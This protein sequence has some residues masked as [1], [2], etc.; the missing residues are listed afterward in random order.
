MARHV[1]ATVLDPP[2]IVAAKPRR[3]R[4]PRL[5]VWVWLIPLVMTMG[6]LALVVYA[7]ALHSWSVF[8]YGTAVA[9]AGIITGGLVGFIFGVPRSASGNQPGGSV[10]RYQDNSNLEQ[11][12]D[13]LTKILVG[14][15]LVQ[16]GRAPNGL[17]HL[18]S[19]MKPGFGGNPSSA[20]FGLAFVIFYAGTGF[21]YLYLWTRTGFLLQLRYLTLRKWATKAA[22]TKAM[23]VAEVT[24]KEKLSKIQTELRDVLSIV[25]RALDPNS[26]AD[27]SSQG[28]LNA[29]I[30]RSSS[31]ARQQAFQRAEVHRR[32]NWRTNKSVMELVIPVFRALIASDSEHVYHRNH[33]ELGFALKDKADPEWREALRELT[34]AI[35]IRGQPAS[36][37]GWAVYEAVRTLCRINI[38]PQ[39]RSEQPSSPETAAEIIADLTTAAADSHARTFLGKQDIKHWLVLNRASQGVDPLWE[40]VPELP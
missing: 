38:D 18:A 26:G 22:E 33:G 16:L 28:E 20:G 39:Y 12:S 34:T 35:E 36:E 30:A 27:M 15:G 19:A 31:Y 9:G 37:K 23:Q 7:T 14:V 24:S 29:A 4:P 6:V 8:G 2:P 5:W 17:S 11:I 40:Q 3:R 25:D 10:E 32:A 1:P 13:W 21:L